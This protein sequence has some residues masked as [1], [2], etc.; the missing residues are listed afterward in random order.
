MSLMSQLPVLP[1]ILPLIAAPITILLPRGLAPWAWATLISWLTFIACAVLLYGVANG[2]PVS[3]FL[4]DWAP[5]LG[6]EY[7]IDMANAIVLTLVSGIAAVVFPFA[8]E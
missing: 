3:Y 1:V 6:I 5:P 2:G 7:R 4:G 8:Y